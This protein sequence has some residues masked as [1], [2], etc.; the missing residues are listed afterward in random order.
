MMKAFHNKIERQLRLSAMLV[1]TGLSIQLVTLRINHPLS[2]LVFI[3]VGSPAVLL[4][5]VVFL[6]SVVSE[7]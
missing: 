7:S 4:G 2:F 5:A 1:L 3:L 6:W